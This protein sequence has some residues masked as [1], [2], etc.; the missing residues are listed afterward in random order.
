MRGARRPPACGREARD[1]RAARRAPRARGG[2][3]RREALPCGHAR[4]G[5]GRTRPPARARA[6]L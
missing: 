4:V 1:P 2:R 6:R 3:V 5:F